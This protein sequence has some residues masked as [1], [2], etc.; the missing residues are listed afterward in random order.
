MQ[1]IRALLFYYLHEHERNNFMQLVIIEKPSV[2]IALAKTLDATEKKDG[3][4]LGMKYGVTLTSLRL[5]L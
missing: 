3:Y 4:N 2:K 1:Y 5:K